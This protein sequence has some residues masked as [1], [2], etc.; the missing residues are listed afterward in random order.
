MSVFRPSNINR[1]L[2]GTATTNTTL[3]GRG[4]PGNGGQI[5]PKKTPYICG[6]VLELGKRC[7]FGSNAGLF[8]ANESLCGIKECCQ[9]TL[10]DCKGFFIC[11]GPSTNKWF[12]A[13]SCTEVSRSWYS[14]GDAVTVACSCMGDCGWFLPTCLQLRDPGYC[15]R[16]YWDSYGSCQYWS[17]TEAGGRGAYGINFNTG[18]SSIGNHHNKPEVSFV[19]AFRCTAT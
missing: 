17:D 5:G 8:K 15:C 7:I 3:S 11:C 2:V 6:N 18:C 16:N 1:R 10:V 9:C 12:V 4:S 13:P 19:R 14:R